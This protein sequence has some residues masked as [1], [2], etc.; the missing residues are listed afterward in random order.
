MERTS[1]ADALV[2]APKKTLFVFFNPPD[3]F[4]PAD[5]GEPHTKSGW[6][7]AS[8]KGGGQ[9]RSLVALAGIDGSNTLTPKPWTALVAPL[10]CRA[11]G[12]AVAHLP[13]ALAGWQAGE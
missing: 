10:V 5:I 2:A 3:L 11:T 9:S 4:Q 6:G 7:C 13:S 1:W 8:R 12:R